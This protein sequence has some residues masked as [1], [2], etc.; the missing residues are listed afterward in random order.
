MHRPGRTESSRGRPTALG[1]R[2]VTTRAAPR[3]TA[4]THSRTA[5][6]AD[7]G[8]ATRRTMSGMVPHPEHTATSVRYERRTDWRLGHRAFQPACGGRMH[9]DF[10]QARRRA[11]DIH[12]ATLFPP[13]AAHHL[14][15]PVRVD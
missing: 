10:A 13:G 5:T 14:R 15:T 3:P 7:A 8:S 9:T 12:H 6:M 2:R 4:A 1:R 11:A